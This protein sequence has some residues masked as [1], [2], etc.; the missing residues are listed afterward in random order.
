ME[1]II[2]TK[3]FS[4]NGKLDPSIKNISKYLH[5]LLETIVL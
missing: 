2:K 3:K 5:F 4:Q 1:G